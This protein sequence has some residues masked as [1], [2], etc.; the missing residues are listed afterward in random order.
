[1]LLAAKLAR[2]SLVLG[3]VDFFAF[4]LLASI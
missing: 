2:H 3:P 4:F 1:V